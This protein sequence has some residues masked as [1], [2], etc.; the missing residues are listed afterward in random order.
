VIKDLQNTGYYLRKVTE[1][2]GKYLGFG[3]EPAYF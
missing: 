3:G 2:I 1:G